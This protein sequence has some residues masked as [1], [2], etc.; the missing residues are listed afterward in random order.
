MLEPF[1]AFA[2]NM[3]LKFVTH[4]TDKYKILSLTLLL[5]VLRILCIVIPLTRYIL[6]SRKTYYILV[7]C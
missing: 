3:S 5:G 7:T 6:I 1:Q 2:I 4:I